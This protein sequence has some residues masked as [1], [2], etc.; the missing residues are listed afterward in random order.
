MNTSLLSLGRKVTIARIAF[1][2]SA[3]LRELG[4]DQAKVGKLQDSCREMSL[5]LSKYGFLALTFVA[6]LQLL[7][8]VGCPSRSVLHELSFVGT[9]ED[10]SC[11]ETLIEG[12]DQS[13]CWLRLFLFGEPAMDAIK[14]LFEEYRKASSAGF[15][16]CQC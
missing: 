9:D 10:R 11:L 6:P 13:K 14:R 1:A 16:P 12:I 3:V 4:S 8:R 5:R 2:E 15:P 7:E